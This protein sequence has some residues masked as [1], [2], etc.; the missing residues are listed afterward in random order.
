LF[1]LLTSFQPKPSSFE[2]DTSDVPYYRP[3]LK[4]SASAR[5]RN[6]LRM[7]STPSLPVNTNHNFYHQHQ[8]IVI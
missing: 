5:P 6:Y 3:T 8:E 4:A 2:E 1:Q 7:D